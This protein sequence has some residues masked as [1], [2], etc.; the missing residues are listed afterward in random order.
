MAGDGASA[1][2]VGFTRTAQM[3]P[4]VKVASP[5]APTSAPSAPARRGTV[6]QISAPIVTSSVSHAPRV[7]SRPP[8]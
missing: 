8:V 3:N 6:C 2:I 7:I 1:G 5:T 4:G